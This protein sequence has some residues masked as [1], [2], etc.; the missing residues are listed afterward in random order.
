MQTLLDQINR[1][2]VVN[3]VKLLG[4]APNL[5]VSGLTGGGLDDRKMLLEQLITLLASMPVTSKVSQTLSDALINI[6]WGDL[7]HP[8]VSFLG[9]EHRFRRPDGSDNNVQNPKLGASN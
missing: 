7:P 4:Q 1:S 6:I 9:R 5:L 8:A 3:D 2:R